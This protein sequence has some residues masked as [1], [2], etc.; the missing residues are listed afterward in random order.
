MN[1]QP[2][3]VTVRDRERKSPVT[4]VSLEPSIESPD[5]LSDYDDGEYLITAEEWENYNQSVNN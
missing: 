2:I 5:D 4:I 3:E 1:F